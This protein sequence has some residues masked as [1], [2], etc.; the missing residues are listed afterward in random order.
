[1]NKK[2]LKTLLIVVSVIFIVTTGCKFNRIKKSKDTELKFKAAQDY[3]KE[4]KYAKAV[5]LYE[6]MYLLSKGKKR[7]QE[8]HFNMAKANYYMKN[9]IIAGYYFRKY[10][11]TY[12]KS[13]HTEEA[14]FMSAYCYFLDTPKT[15]LEQSS[16]H[17]ALQE[18]EHFI[19]KYPN[20][21]K[22]PECNEIIDKLRGKLE[23]KSYDNAYLY[24][25]IGSYRAA[26][27]A[28]KNS[29][30]DFPDSKYREEVYFYILKSNFLYAK[31]SIKA[32]Q[33]ERYTTTMK[34]YKKFVEKFPDSKFMKEA[35]KIH[36][37]INKKLS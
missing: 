5:I 3:Y 24:Y 10:V 1:M 21:P 6:D 28:L 2:I 16:T 9:Y 33:K 37:K 25:K 22:I 14:H 17:T 29:L 31:N 15:K 11:E 19:S 36:D 18:F 35:K 27:V 32:K 20:S 8:I 26:T 30:L 7:G 13:K 23:K 12:P 34:A 4:G